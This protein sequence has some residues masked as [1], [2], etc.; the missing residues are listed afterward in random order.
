MKFP[1]RPVVVAALDNDDYILLMR[2][3]IP[4]EIAGASGTMVLSALVDTGADNTILPL[5]VA[6]SLQIP[7][8]E[9]QGTQA[10]VFGGQQVRLFS[11]EVDFQL[12]QGD[13]LLCWSAGVQFF[14][15]ADP[16]EETAVLGHAGF[17][18]YFTATFDGLDA[19]LTL[20]PNTDLPAAS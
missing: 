13:E 2:P 18:D 16:N 5:S 4:I 12:R 11:G 8:H 6:V 9:A 15:F 3:E 14:D 7:V 19:I 10:K 1:Y 17:L 20:V